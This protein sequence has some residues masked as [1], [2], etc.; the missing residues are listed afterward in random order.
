MNINGMEK[1]IFTN[2]HFQMNVGLQNDNEHERKKDNIVY[3]IAQKICPIRQSGAKL[4][5]SV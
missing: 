3:G 2:A 1:L 5:R 4:Y